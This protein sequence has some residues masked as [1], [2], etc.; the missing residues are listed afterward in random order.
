MLTSPVALGGHVAGT[1]ARVGGGA[2]PPA[3]LVPLSSQLSLGLVLVHV[4]EAALPLS[5]G[6]RLLS[7]P[8]PR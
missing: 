6:S 2:L 3:S 7:S 8:S 1:E 4:L 5:E